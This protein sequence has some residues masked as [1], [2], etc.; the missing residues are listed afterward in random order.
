[1]GLLE[2]ST[3]KAVTLHYSSAEMGEKATELRSEYTDAMRHLYVFVRPFSSYKS[4]ICN[5]FHWL[6]TLKLHSS[7]A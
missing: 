6:I 4:G 2:T 3:C 1:M 7:A 5:A